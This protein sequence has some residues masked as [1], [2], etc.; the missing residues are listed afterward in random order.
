MKN[1][2]ILCLALFAISMTSCTTPDQLSLTVIKNEEGYL[3]KEGEQDVLFYQQ[4]PKSLDGNYSRSNYIHPLY[5]LDGEIL[6]EDFPKDHLHQRG[7][8][9]AW[10]QLWIGD[11]RIGDGWE[12][13]DFSWNVTDVQ[14]VESDPESVALHTHVYWQ[15]PLWTDK[16]GQEKPFVEEKAIIRIYKS[17]NNKRAIDFQISLLALE[18]N[19]RFGGSEDQKGYGGFSPRFKCPQDLT[20]TAQIGKVTPQTLQIEAGPW[21]DFSATFGE[22]NQKSGIALLCHPSLPGFPQRWII[23]QAKSM[24]NAV[25]PGSEPVALP[26]DQP[27]LLR[28][29]LI[30]HRGD[31]SKIELEKLQDQYNKE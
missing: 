30:V 19:V 20:F 24:Q 8:F 7:V 18:E 11:K 5:G 16:N 26:N 28:Y 12:I 29:R 21:L 17:T 25:Y 22:N 31:A 13:K 10:H 15:S 3:V 1:H 23:R 27:L 9:W 6:T 2:F 4:K 14:I